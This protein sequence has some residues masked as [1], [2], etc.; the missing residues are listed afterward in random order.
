MFEY[1]MRHAYVM[2]HGQRMLPPRHYNRPYAPL[3]TSNHL[4]GQSHSGN[5]L[6]LSI[7][8]ENDIYAWYHTYS[9]RRRPQGPPFSGNTSCR[10]SYYTYVSIVPSR[11]RLLALFCMA[12]S[13]SMYTDTLSV[14]SLRHIGRKCKNLKPTCSGLNFLFQEVLLLAQSLTD[15]C[16]LQY[17]S[18]L[19]SS[20]CSYSSRGLL[21]SQLLWGAPI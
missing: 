16:V 5:L 20:R 3:L 18:C 7:W 6:L 19:S 15:T 8:P 9:P 12:V 14:G 13:I 17:M 4:Y 21:S 11:A 1:V 10:T 2:R